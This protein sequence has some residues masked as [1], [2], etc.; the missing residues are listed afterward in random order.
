M[1]YKVFLNAIL[2][3]DEQKFGM[4]TRTTQGGILGVSFSDF[5]MCTTDSQTQVNK[6]NS[7]KRY[8]Q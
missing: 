6:L 5:W 4:K 3:S 7:Q 8:V 1:M 2:E